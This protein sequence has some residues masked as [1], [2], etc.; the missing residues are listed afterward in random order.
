[1]DTRKHYENFDNSQEV[2]TK[3]FSLKTV[4]TAPMTM[5]RGEFR[6]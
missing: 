6:Y 3:T 4:L 2:I 1:M 5:R